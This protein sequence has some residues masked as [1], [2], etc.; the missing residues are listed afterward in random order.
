MWAS[1]TEQKGYLQHVADTALVR[2]MPETAT[3]AILAALARAVVELAGGAVTFVPRVLGVGL[4]LD[5]ERRVGLA[6]V[7]LRAGIVAPPA[8]VVFVVQG[9]LHLAHGTLLREAGGVCRVEAQQV[10]KVWRTR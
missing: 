9:T 6:R 1:M 5:L 3:R 2:R 7:V 10:P 8:Q 4:V